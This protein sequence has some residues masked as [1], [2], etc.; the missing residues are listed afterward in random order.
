[1]FSHLYELALKSVPAS[2]LNLQI[3]SSLPPQ[4]QPFD[5][6]KPLI[7]ELDSIATMKVPANKK[8][9]PATETI[10][11]SRTYHYN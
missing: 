10:I 8:I 1:M 7:P 4:I 5:I 9:P 2:E 3:V 6:V 11:A